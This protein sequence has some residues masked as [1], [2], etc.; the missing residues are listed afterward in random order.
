ME[1]NKTEAVTL[2]L[3]AW[4]MLFW[5]QTDQQASDFVD[6]LVCRIDSYVKM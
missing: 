2:L 5:M 1:Q 6:C 3:C 4:L